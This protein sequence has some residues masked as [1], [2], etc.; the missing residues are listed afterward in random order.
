M[1]A[2]ADAGPTRGA[3]QRMQIGRMQGLRHG[4]FSFVAFDRNEPRTAGCH[5]FVSDLSLLCCTG[6]NDSRAL[7]LG[8]CI[9]SNF[10]QIAT[11]E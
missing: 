7:V 11:K 10:A 1:S 5:A 4:Q 9:P 6:Q 3:N 8:G 2:D